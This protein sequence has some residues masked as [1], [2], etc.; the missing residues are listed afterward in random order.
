MYYR[1]TQNSN[2]LNGFNS[3]AKNYVI[4]IMYVLLETATHVEC[5]AKYIQVYLQK[6]VHFN[7]IKEFEKQKYQYFTSF[8]MSNSI[9]IHIKVGLHDSDYT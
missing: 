1:K 6:Y 9:P 4:K 2:S 7:M 5:K 8:T 3:Y